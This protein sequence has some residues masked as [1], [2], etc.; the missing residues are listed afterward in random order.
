MRRSIESGPIDSFSPE[1]YPLRRDAR[2]VRP[3]DNQCI[4][5]GVWG[6]CVL[7]SYAGAARDFKKF[8]V[9]CLILNFY[10]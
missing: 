10:L 8:L 4:I 7:C 5:I 3:I 1:L 6:L 9:R 2:L